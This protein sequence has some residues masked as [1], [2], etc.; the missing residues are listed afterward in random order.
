MIHEQNFQAY[1]D[2][3]LIIVIIISSL[4]SQLLVFPSCVRQH[5]WGLCIS[6][7][8]RQCP[9][10]VMEKVAAV[11][12]V[13]WR[14]SLLINISVYIHFTTNCRHNIWLKSQVACTLDLLLNLLM[15]CPQHATRFIQFNHV[16]HSTVSTV[17]IKTDEQNKRK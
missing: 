9:C 7:R 16:L 6:T 13:S 1:F 3:I 2:L 4:A 15:S 17:L 10:R 11:H 12:V 8:R 5:Q 14:K